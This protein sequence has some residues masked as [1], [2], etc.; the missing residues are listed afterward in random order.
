VPDGSN[1]L[2]Q[3]TSST[4]ATGQVGSRGGDFRF[5]PY[6]ADIPLN[7]FTNSSKVRLFA[8]SG[9][10]T[11]S[12]EPDAGWIYQPFTGGLWCDGP[13]LISKY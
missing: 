3:M 9:T 1:N 13:V 2:S 7:L 11:A 8:A 10:P 12:G 6:L 5:G 4:D